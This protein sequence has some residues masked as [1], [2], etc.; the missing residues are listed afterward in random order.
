M[1]ET[2]C[3][4][5]KWDEDIDYTCTTCGFPDV[6]PDAMT[7]AYADPPYPGQAAKHYKDHEDYDGEV[8]HKALIERLC[9][10]YPDGWA[11]STSSSALQYV[12]SLCP[13][14]VR[15]MA[16]V[17]PFASFKPNVN[18]GYC[19]E[20]VIVRG[21]RKRGRDVPTMRDF[22]VCNITLKKGLS[23]AKPETFNL[24]LFEIFG[25][26]QGDVLHDL[27]SGTGGVMRDWEMFQ[28]GEKK[29]LKQ[30]I[31]VENEVEQ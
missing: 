13:D 2:P 4:V 5:C 31:S 12:L 29:L 20:P 22:V 24:W 6:P 18:P 17:K 25:A 7:F 23:G 28:S 27:F 21:G 3:P 1:T 16:W 30:K 10:E 9:E 15:V 14:D 8:D 19:W 26:K 11:L